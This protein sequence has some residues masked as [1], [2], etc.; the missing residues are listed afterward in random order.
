MYPDFSVS[1]RV[2]LLYN[3]I[4]NK[5]TTLY[6]KNM[7]NT[8]AKSQTYT[9]VS[10]PSLSDLADVKYWI[11]DIDD[12][13]Y[14]RSC[15]LDRIIQNAITE[16]ICKDLNIEETQARELCIEYYH[17]YGS[18]IRGLMET[19]DVKPR[20]FVREVHQSLDLSCIKPNA[21]MNTAMAKIPG[22]KYV[23]TNGSYCH[24]LRICKKLGIEKNIDGFFGA[25]STNFIPKPDPRA[26]NEFFD[27]YRIEPKEAIFF[28]D[29][30]RNL[31]AINK[32]G[33][34]TVWIAESLQELD[35]YKI[36]PVY[37][38]YA[39]ADITRWMEELTSI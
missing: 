24:G 32:M 9:I 13:L 2:N 19:T 11:F 38:D 34:K 26:F 27:R 31:E 25:Q 8:I 33:T 10:A 39:T 30:F 29:S 6:K 28:D 12:T 5:L 35:N 18:T 21:R 4:L 14:P 36:L 17:Q 23:F 37:V 7:K 20:K 16:H 22:K 1:L 15:G 3:I